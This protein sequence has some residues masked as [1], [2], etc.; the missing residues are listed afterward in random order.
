LPFSA[1]A[2]IQRIPSVAPVRAIVRVKI[3]EVVEAEPEQILILIKA[4]ILKVV[5]VRVLYSGNIEVILPKQ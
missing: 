2:V 1:S 4:Y 3:L 5:V